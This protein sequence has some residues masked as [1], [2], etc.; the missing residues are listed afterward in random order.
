MDLMAC[1]TDW[2]RVYIVGSQEEVA[3]EALADKILAMTSSRSEKRFQTYE[4]AYGRSF[5][6]MMRRVPCL[7]RIHEM[8]GFE[9]VTSLTE[10]LE[11]VIAEKGQLLGAASE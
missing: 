4:Q 10:I 6:D 8:V 9:P 1:G 5:D 2:G 3:I 7:D 11:T